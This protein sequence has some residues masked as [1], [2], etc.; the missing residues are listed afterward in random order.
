MSP[1]EVLQSATIE[2]A[3]LMRQEGSIGE[4][5]TGAW[6]D[7]LVVEGDPTIDLSTLADPQRGVLLIMKAG[8]IYRD[9]MAR[10]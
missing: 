4:I 9:D 1:V 5:V 7:L 2:A 8:R 10:H 6:A 3:R